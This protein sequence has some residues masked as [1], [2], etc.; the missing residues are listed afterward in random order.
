MIVQINTTDGSVIGAQ[1]AITDSQGYE[2]FCSASLI[3]GYEF[4]HPVILGI[5]M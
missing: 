3:E 4:E 2:R 5:Q 1:L